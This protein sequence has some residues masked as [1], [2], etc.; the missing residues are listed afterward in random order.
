MLKRDAGSG[1]TAPLLIAKQPS[2][3]QAISKYFKIVGFV[4]KCPF[5]HSGRSRN[6]TR[7]VAGNFVG[8]RQLLVCG[9]W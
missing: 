9:L 2:L 1:A 7:S 5:T 8:D 3:R 4:S 6:R